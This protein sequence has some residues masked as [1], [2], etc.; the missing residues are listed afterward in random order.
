MEMGSPFRFALAAVALLA[1]HCAS[2]P[3]ARDAH[4]PA[5]SFLEDDYAGAIASAR[6]RGLP[7][8]IEA[9]APW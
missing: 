6:E 7:V 3:R 5:I 4:A 8:F 1:V 9:W 2:S